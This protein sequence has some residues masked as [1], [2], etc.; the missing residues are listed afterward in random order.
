MMARARNIKPSFFKNEL[1]VEMGAFDRLLF[2]GLWCLADREGRIEDRPKRIKMELF[3]CDAYDVDQGL[4]ELERAG[5]VKRYEANG[6]RVILIVNFIKH[7]TPHG[8]EKDSLLPDENGEMTVNERTE[9]GY[10]TGIK[11]K[12]NV[13]KGADNGGEQLGNGE[14]R[15]SPQGK[16]PL[17]PDSLI[18]DSL[19]PECGLGTTAPA[20]QAQKPAKRATQIPADFY[21]NETGVGYAEERRVNLAVEMESFRNYH[22]AKGS[23]F[24]DWQ[25]AWRTWCD[26]A[27][28]F[29]RTGSTAK[30]PTES[31]YERD[32]RLKAQTV[33]SFAPGIAA[34]APAGFDF[35]EGGVKDVAAIESH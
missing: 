17:N 5:F 14:E 22:Q 6:V 30:Q 33:A 12:N 9:N 25:A 29:G 10:A 1:L 20:S 34:K 31:F 8:T 4:S 11:R 32:Q 3:P 15:V 7:Q 35:I 18:P 2:V 24:K 16:N 19:N 26:K 28:E 27:V 23:T 21:P 13:K